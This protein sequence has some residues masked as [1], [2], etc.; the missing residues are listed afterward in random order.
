MKIPS[1]VSP[2]SS[3]SA[4]D[5]NDLLD[6]V[7]ALVPRSGP[8][9]R[10][11]T[12]AG[13]TTMG[14]TGRIPKRGGSSEFTH[15]FKITDAGEGIV[16]VAYGTINDIS[17]TLSVD[18]SASDATYL[19]YA[20]A[21]LDIDGL[22]TAVNLS[23]TSSSLPA[24]T[25]SAAHILLGEV[26]ITDGAVSAMEQAVT[27]SLRF[28]ACGRTNDGGVTVISRGDYHFWGV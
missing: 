14:F 21:T 17:D 16:D 22:V 10:V 20:E 19:V 5:Y 26:T 11:Q 25:D 8:G 1:R 28:G 3:V 27:H 4:K 23:T 7:K 2:G 15:P 9:I 13:G 6:C 12:T 18:L 24:D